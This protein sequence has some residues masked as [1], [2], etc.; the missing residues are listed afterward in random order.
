MKWPTRFPRFPA[1]ATPLFS[2][3][4]LLLSPSLSAQEGAVAGTITGETSEAPLSSVQVEVAGPEGNVVGEALTGPAGRFRVSGLAPGGY[5]VVASLP[6]YRTARRPDVVVRAGETTRLSIALAPAAIELNPITV[7]AARQ[8]EKLLEAPASI[9][10]VTRQEVEE[11]P[12]ISTLGHLEGIAG[13]DVMRAGL[14]QGYAVTRGF[15][16]VFSGAMLTLTDYRIARVPSLRA[17][18]SHLNP[19]TNPDIERIEVVRGPG[20]A[21]YGPNAANGVL[22]T[23][24]KSPIDDPESVIS[25][26]GGLRQQDAVTGFESSEEAVVHAEGRIARRFGDRFGVKVSGQYFAGRDYL[27]RDPAEEEARE[28][29]RDCLNAPGGAACLSFPA[30]TSEERLRRVGDRD[31]DLERWAVD[32]RADWRPSDDVSA[33]LSAGRTLAATSID[34]TGIG[35][36]QV[37]DFASSYYQARLNWDDLFAQ[38]FLNRSGAGDT[39]LLQTGQPIDDQSS[40]LV[41]QLQHSSALGERQLL[42]YGVDVLRTTPVTNGSITGANERDDETT[43]LGAYLQAERAL[44]DRLELIL[45]ARG[46]YHS[47]LDKGIFSPRAALVFRPAPEHRLR[48][49]YNRA[50]STP[51]TN[52]LFLDIT[53]R[54]FTVPGTPA[55]Y[56]VQ[57]QGTTGEGFRFENIGG[58]PAM[59]SPFVADPTRFLPTDT[60]TLWEIAAGI[61]AAEDPATGAFL[62]GLEPSEDDISTVLR[63]LNTGEG[64]P[65]LPFEGGI[66]SLGDIPAIREE[67]TNTFE[68]GYKGLLRESLL[69]SADAYYTIMENFI[70]PLRVETP[71][72]FLDGEETAEFLAGEGLSPLA[73]GQLAGTLAQIPLGVVQP[74]DA[75]PAGPSV[76]LTYRNF[77][78]VRVA[79]LDLAADYEVADRWSLGL[80]ASLVSDDEFDADGVDVA[81]NAPTFKARAS[82]RYRNE[83]AGFGGGASVRHVNGFPVNSGVF[84][85]EIDD[86]RVVD[87][88]VAYRLRTLE[89]VTFQLDVSNLLD[90]GHRT[91]VGV[92]ELGRFAMARLQYAF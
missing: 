10:V 39:Y 48:A 4:F 75:S 52:N 37:D 16:N 77:G 28:R 26:G 43:E 35:T 73:A 27:F 17:N 38:V 87:L 59:K 33:I 14:Q 60:P 29:A 67:T 46:D 34:L 57:A 85:G 58:R 69:L 68:A 50:Y 71:N 1:P 13:M 7:S 91:F 15:N 53:A 40:L 49:T 65:F 84:V 81:L 22:H 86:Y 19:T 8:Q 47:V 83:E 74:A 61:V 42:V 36:A 12:A 54:R 5:A 55:S 51:T 63:I 24:T 9:T 89:G 45:A 80:A 21:L 31:F 41:G 2:L 30:G 18:I 90:S 20:S 6:G 72:V 66:G 78:T 64:D 70:G 25:L 44:S 82:A 23:I 32:L 62:A 56:G 3:P 92:P 79:G 11:R 88:N 76:L